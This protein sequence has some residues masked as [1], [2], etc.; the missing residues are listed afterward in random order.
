MDGGWA[1][2]NQWTCDV[3][4]GTGTRTRTRSCTNPAPAHGGNDC[5]GTSQETSACILSQ[6]PGKLLL[7]FLLPLY[8]LDILYILYQLMV[9]G[10]DGSPGIRVARRWTRHTTQGE[11]L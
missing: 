6:C 8:T 1:D 5:Q 7:H 10:V 3:S 2:W 11:I 4:C 9:D